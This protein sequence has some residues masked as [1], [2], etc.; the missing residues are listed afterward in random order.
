MKP[1]EAA[2]H[3]EHLQH[4]AHGGEHGGS[5]KRIAIL[6][7]VLAAILAIVESGGKAKQTEQLAKNIDASDTYAFYQAKTIRSTVLRTSSALVE[8]VVPE[9]VSAERKAKL[10]KTLADWKESADRYD[11]DPKSGEGRKELIE[12]AK[13]L[14][15]ERDEAAMAYHNFEYGAA[16]LQ[17][18]IVLASASVIT[19]MPVLALFSIG[20]G[21]VGTA[22]GAAGWFAPDALHNL[23]SGGHGGSHGG[24]H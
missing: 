4:T 11:S 10:D 16:A 2:E 1:D 18:S 12:K 17:L 20:L 7:A 14:T 6:I 8:S 21:G 19:G 3:H 9:T 15:A 23:L 5:G 24:G 22:L 13:H